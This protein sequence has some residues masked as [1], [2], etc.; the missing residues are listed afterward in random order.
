MTHPLSRVV[1]TFGFVGCLPAAPGTWASGI[2]LLLWWLLPPAGIL[3]TLLLWAFLLIGGTL[4]ASRAEAVYG[5]DDHR[6]VIDEVAGSFLAV[7][8]FAPE[9]RIAILAFLLFRFFD[10]AKPPPI[11]QLQA[12]PGGWGVMVDDL[13]AGLFA[14]GAIRLI[15]LLAPQLAGGM[16]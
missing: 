10:I 8:G 6:I 14:N 3:L 12:L 5:H 7:A 11:Y 1:A 13:A 2:T 15:L 9:L 16:G 4:S